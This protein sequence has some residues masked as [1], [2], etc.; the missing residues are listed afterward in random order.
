MTDSPH[1]RSPDF[2][3]HPLRRVAFQLRRGSGLGLGLVFAV[4]CVSGSLLTDAEMKPGPGGWRAKFKDPFL[5]WRPATA[6][7][8]QAEAGE[9]LI[10]N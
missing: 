7:E 9:T 3:K 4:V 5:E 6:G 1:S 2:R 10:R 8:L